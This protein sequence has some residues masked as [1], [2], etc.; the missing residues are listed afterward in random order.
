MLTW[1]QFP[2]LP[3]C[4]SARQAPAPGSRMDPWHKVTAPCIH[5]ISKPTPTPPDSPLGIPG[6]MSHSPTHDPTLPK[7]DGVLSQVCGS[8][9]H[10]PSSGEGDGASFIQNYLHSILDV[11]GK[12]S[13]HPGT[14]LVALGA[15]E[16]WGSGCFLTMR[17]GERTKDPQPFLLDPWAPTPPL[18]YEGLE[19]DGPGMSL[20]AGAT[21]SVLG[22]SVPWLL[23]FISYGCCHKSLQTECL[24]TTHTYSLIGLKVRSLK[25]V[26]KAEIQVSQGHPFWGLQTPLDPCLHSWTF[27]PSFPPVKASVASSSLC[28]LFSD[29]CFHCHISSLSEPPTSLF[30]WEDPTWGHSHNSESSPHLKV[31]NSICKIP[32][33]R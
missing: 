30:P 2:D 17:G 29:L 21:L 15:L 24:K 20:W 14:S 4:G 10:L 32:D 27:D 5:C 1:F 11:I 33:T 3:Q 22:K 28:P 18:H 8:E 19:G 23:E 6:P 26:P 9:S 16:V 12:T 7:K 25:W 31:L 13:I